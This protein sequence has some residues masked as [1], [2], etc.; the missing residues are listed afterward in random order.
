M[1]YITKKQFFYLH[2][3]VTDNYFIFIMDFGGVAER[4]K[5]QVC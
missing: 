5:A 2:F 1:I 3:I 4:L